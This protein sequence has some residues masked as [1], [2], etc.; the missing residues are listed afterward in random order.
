VTHDPGVVEEVADRVVVMQT[1]RM[2]EEG[3]R[4]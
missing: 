3:P 4:G 1:G 2:V